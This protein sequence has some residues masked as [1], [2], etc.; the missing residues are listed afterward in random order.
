M[1]IHPYQEVFVNF[2]SEIIHSNKVLFIYL[3]EEKIPLS[4]NYP[5]IYLLQTDRSMNEAAKAFNAKSKNKAIIVG[6]N[7]S[8]QEISD[9]D[10]LASFFKRELIPY[11]NANYPTLNEP[12]QRVV[13]SRG[14][15]AAKLA[16]A[17][18]SSPEV[19]FKAILVSPENIGLDALPLSKES[20]IF[21][22]GGRQ[23]LADLQQ[24]LTAS[25]LQYGKNF[26]YQIGFYASVFDNLDTDY[27]FAAPQEVTVKKLSGKVK[28]STLSLSE[29]GK[30]VF[31]ARAVL[32]NGQ[33]FDFIP[34][35]F[36]ISPMYLDWDAAAGT[37]A[38]IRGAEAG[39]VK[40]TATAADAE[41]QTFIRL[42]K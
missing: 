4:K 31:S 18:I 2:P 36:K 37:L 34:N 42:K 16:L 41:L 40:L 39:K 14:P 20:R 38:V 27:L 22:R 21:A 32:N 11:I 3:P 13:V 15:V 28:P 24:M 17:V 26:A 25:G 1:F 19:A 10:K 5:V 33:Q 7:F 29:P 35:N 8:D 23:G 30:A 12:A 9:T 6:L